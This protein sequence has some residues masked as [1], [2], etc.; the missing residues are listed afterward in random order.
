[1]TR[2]SKREIER[3]IQ[4]FGGADDSFH[5]STVV[6]RDP[7]TGKLYD[8]WGPE[9]D[10]V[11]TLPDGDPFVIRRSETVRRERALADDREILEDVEDA[12]EDIVVVR[13]EPGNSVDTDAAV[14]LDDDG[15]DDDAPVIDF[16][17]TDT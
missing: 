1:M 3:G 9:A 7:V 2:K 4:D 17:E 6:H 15:D 16:T 10:P 12:P 8:G 14:V 13:I 5:P 11:E